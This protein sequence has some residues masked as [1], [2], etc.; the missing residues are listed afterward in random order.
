MCLKQWDASKMNI[1]QLL[2]VYVRKNFERHKNNV[3]KLAEY[4][5]LIFKEKQ[6]LNETMYSFL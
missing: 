3:H 1:Y 5:I 2:A 4:E 6:W